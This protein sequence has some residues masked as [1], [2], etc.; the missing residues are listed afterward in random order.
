MCVFVRFFDSL[1][2][3]LSDCMFSVFSHSVGYVVAYWFVCLYTC[4]LVCLCVF[5]CESCL[6]A[7][8]F[9]LVVCF[10]FRGVRLSYNK[11]R[12]GFLMAAFWQHFGN[13]LVMFRV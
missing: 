13:K 6:L 11:K 4:V 5:M 9:E 1:R 7:Y 2:V 12:L 8:S 10:D 3:R